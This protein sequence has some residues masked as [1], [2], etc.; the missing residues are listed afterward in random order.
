MQGMGEGGR[1]EQGREMGIYSTT[2]KLEERFLS[3][4][5]SA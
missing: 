3:D 4:A 2:Q 5:R 1:E